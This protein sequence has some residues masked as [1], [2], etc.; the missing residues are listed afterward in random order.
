MTT[1]PDDIFEDLI[2]PP[3]TTRM[4]MSE[5]Q[6]DEQ[7]YSA[8]EHSSISLECSK[9]VSVPTPKKSLV[10]HTKTNNNKL[11]R[12]PA[13]LSKTRARHSSSPKT[14]RKYSV[15]IGSENAGELS[16]AQV[17]ETEGEDEKEYK[18]RINKSISPP[19]NDELRTIDDEN[20]TP[21]AYKCYTCSATYRH[22]Q[23]VL[24]HKRKTN[25]RVDAIL[26]FDKSDDLMSN[27]PR[28]DAEECYD[29][30]SGKNVT[31]DPVSKE[32]TNVVSV[33]SSTVTTT[34]NEKHVDS[35][36]VDQQQKP[37][38]SIINDNQILRELTEEKLSSI[39]NSPSLEKDISNLSNSDYSQSAPSKQSS[40]QLELQNTST[41][42]KQESYTSLLTDEMRTGHEQNEHEKNLNAS[43]VAYKC[44]TCSSIYRHQQSLKRHKRKTRH[45]ISAYSISDGISEVNT[46]EAL[47]KSCGTSGNK[48][49]V[50]SV[51]RIIHE[52]CS[53][54]AFHE[55]IVVENKPDTELSET[56]SN[57]NLY[58]HDKLKIFESSV[59]TST[60]NTMNNPLN[61]LFR[62]LAEEEHLNSMSV[63]PSVDKEVIFTELHEGGNVSVKEKIPVELSTTVSDISTSDAIP[64]EIAQTDDVATSIESTST[65]TMFIE[66]NKSVEVMNKD[67][68]W[69]KNIQ[70]SPTSCRYTCLWCSRVVKRYPNF[71]KHVAAC[72]DRPSGSE[73]PQRSNT[74]LLSVSSTGGGNSSHHSRKSYPLGLRSSRPSIQSD[75]NVQNTEG[76][77]NTKQL[78]KKEKK[79]TSSC[80]PHHSRVEEES[81]KSRRSSI[82]TQHSSDNCIDDEK[83]IVSNATTIPASDQIVKDNNNNDN[84]N[85][86]LFICSWCNR[87]GF[88]CLRYLNIHSARCSL[89]PNRLTKQKTLVLSKKYPVQITTNVDTVSGVGVGVVCEQC[90]REFR[91]I[92]GLKVHQTMLKHKSNQQSIDKLFSQQ[93]IACPGCSYNSALFDST[94]KLLKHLLTLKSNTSNSHT[95]RSQYWPTVLSVPNL[96][97]GC[98]ICGMLLA[99]ESR[100]D[101]H[102]KAVHETWLLEE[103]H[104]LSPSKLTLSTLSII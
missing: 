73:I 94:E 32:S 61:E 76:I 29:R 74:N 60:I 75:K 57:S 86:T 8:H 33:Q 89:R 101:K 27:S 38:P 55:T 24:R 54:P 31:L 43:P 80:S 96:G 45:R 9:N 93:L 81:S 49:E 20:T 100:L 95:S 82:S 64:E 3:A 19:S 17:S 50:V 22:R 47:E 2:I 41:E 34:D 12:S 79:S 16:S 83:S 13:E 5:S 78:A 58:R 7:D 21:L 87:S 68:S 53:Q 6:H 62:V 14:A 28:K 65:K 77:L 63:E 35:F 15:S 66:E 10:Q 39:M 97:Y 71:I 85:S 56:D 90:N 52:E 104:N 42:Q 92:T 98:H 99:S 1:D 59:K 30:D 88:K 26:S 23:S 72:K 51:D 4:K 69:L 25:H 40:I 84:N 36:D 67:D 11:S 46:T 91:S 70:P 103:Q 48:L 102:K 44:Y 37:S 18:R